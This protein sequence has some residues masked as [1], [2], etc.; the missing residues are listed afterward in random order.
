M[1]LEIVN[2]LS[3]Q[4]LIQEEIGLLTALPSAGQLSI[5]EATCDLITLSEHLPDE[6]MSCYLSSDAQEAWIFLE[7]LP[8]LAQFKLRSSRARE[9][10]ASMNSW[11]EC[12]YK[13]NSYQSTMK[14][15]L[16]EDDESDILLLKS[17]Q[18]CD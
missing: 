12:G 16:Q 13:Q 6:G 9:I 1:A 4:T 14:I 3:W 10:V 11:L 15:T 8:S 5:T 18:F 2:D 7:Y 17:L